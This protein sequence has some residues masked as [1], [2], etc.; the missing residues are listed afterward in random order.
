VNPLVSCVTP[1]KDRRA[2]VP[3]AIRCFLEQDYE[4]KELV[5]LDDGED[6]VGDL[7]PRHPQIRYIRLPRQYVTGEKR[8]LCCEVSKGEIICHADDDD[9]SAPDRISYQVKRLFESGAPITGF[10]T[11]LFWDCRTK[12]A[13]RY[14][15]M[16][17]NYVCGTTFCY[18]RDFWR[19]NPFRHKQQATDNGLIYPVLSR[20][21]ASPETRYMV[22]RIHNVHH[23]SPKANIKDMIDRKLIPAGFWENEEFRLSLKGKAS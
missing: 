11:L 21:D 13:K 20:V 10:N 19:A 22:A 3:A 7:I 4:P 23:T 9:W 18:R 6:S 5:I 14:R 2:F 16:I 8:N 12:Q 1:T 17:R 15:A